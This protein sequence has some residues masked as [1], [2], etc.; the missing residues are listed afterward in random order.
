VSRGE[1]A[2]RVFEDDL[3]TLD[4]VDS[5]VVPGYLVLRLKV[6]ADSPSELS[7]AAAAAFGVMIA[8]AARAIERATAAERVYCLSFGELDR[9]LHVH[10]FPRTPWVLDAYRR[11]T[12]TH[13]EPTNGPALFEWART[14]LVDAAAVPEGVA[15][16][17][18]VC[19]TLRAHLLTP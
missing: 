5:C 7:A 10:L 12:D 14:T 15:G 11:A 13:H 1:P 2:L 18:E 8:H 4:H 3:F 17:S 6:A 19:A 16:V 9:R